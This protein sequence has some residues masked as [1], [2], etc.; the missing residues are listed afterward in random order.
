MS[1][2]DELTSPVQ[3]KLLFGIAG[4]FFLLGST[5]SF[6]A[7][8]AYRAEFPRAQRGVESGSIVEYVCA[9]AG[10][11]LGIVLLL[12]RT[13]LPARLASILPLLGVV[14]L[15]APMLASQRTTPTDAI[16]LLWPV[17]YAGC[18][19]SV[20]VAWVT[21][22]ASLIALVASS[23]I[24][25]RL[26]LVGYGPM[27]VTL[28]LTVCVVV[29]LQHRLHAVVSEFERRA[30][31]DVLTGLANR[32]ELVE[33]L[34]REAA[35]HRRRGSALSVLMI[36]ADRF[37]QINDTA[38]H[39][40]GDDVLRRLGALLRREFRQ[41]DLAARFGG[42]EFMVILIDCSV[43]D[44]AARAEEL[45]ALIAAESAAWPHTMT[46]SIG[47]AELSLDAPVSEG[48]ASLIRHADGALYAAKQSG[49]NRVRVAEA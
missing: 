22:A 48:S 42:E 18:L 7:A 8:L 38:G 9:A 31:T 32:R 10:G 21:T 5:V 45:R 2:P 26:T 41:G 11:C 28:V 12:A 34:G 15:T 4:I 1:E 17:L 27:A 35:A 43:A 24:D 16:L 20:E 23:L 39:D 46:V 6:I 44:A 33:T 36:D 14:L 25:P 49:R 13:R 40:V 19:L 29:S 3:G 47:V 37:K 30:G